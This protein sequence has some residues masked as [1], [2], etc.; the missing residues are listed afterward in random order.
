MSLNIHISTCTYTYP[1]NAS[2]KQNPA[3]LWMM[4]MN[5][6]Y[7]ISNCQRL[8]IILY[9]D[10]MMLFTKLTGFRGIVSVLYTQRGSYTTWK[11]MLAMTVF[12][13]RR[14]VQLSRLPVHFFRLPV[15]SNCMKQRQPVGFARYF[16]TNVQR[17]P[18]GFARYFETNP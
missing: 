9:S 14:W 5:F 17:Q 1:H 7:H 16:E 13:V 15:M 4:L 11:A 12:E 2:Q 10:S 3:S 8:D 6:V 18:V